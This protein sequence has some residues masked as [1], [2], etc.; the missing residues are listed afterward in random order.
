MLGSLSSLDK[1]NKWLWYELLYQIL[2]FFRNSSYLNIGDLV[3]CCRHP[4]LVMLY[5]EKSWL[6]WSSD[7]SEVFVMIIPLKGI[8]VLGPILGKYLLYVAEQES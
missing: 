3:I 4:D 2:H 5:Y 8:V 7:K 6:S 1:V